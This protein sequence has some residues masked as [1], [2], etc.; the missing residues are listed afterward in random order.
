MA[1]GS[2]R[3]VLR[4]VASVVGALVVLLVALTL[5]LQTSAVSERVKDLVVPK[6]SAALGREVAVRAAKLRL[7]PHARVELE[8]T[9]VAGRPGEPPLVQLDAFEVGVRVWP[10]VTS[11][12][13]N[14]QVNEIRLVRPVVNLVR[15]KDGTW[16]YEGLGG[17]TEA[18]AEPA[19]QTKEGSGGTANV[20]VDHAAI[21]NGEV[22]YIDAL[23]GAHAAVA[24]SK[25]DLSAADVGLGHPLVAKISAAIVNPEKNFELD[26]HASKLPASLAALGPGQYPELEGRMALTGLDLSRVRAFMP[27]SVTH[28]MTGGRVDASA[29]LATEQGKYRVDGDGK[30]SQVRLR[31]EPAQGGFELHAI[32]DPATGAGTAS[33]EKIAL[34]GPGVDLGGNVTADLKPPRV[35]FAIAGPLLDLG[36]VMG[37]LPQEQKP[38]EQQPKKQ[39]G[40]LLTAEQRGHVRALD[41]AGTVDIHKV[42]KGGL[43]ANDFHAKAV[44]EHGVF[45]LQDA[46]TQFFGGRVDSG[47]TRVDLAQANPAWNLKAKLQAVDVGQAMQSLSG[48]APL[49]GKL[50]GTVDL[51]GAGVDWPAV[52]KVLTGHGVLSLKEGE[53][54]TADL[55]GQARGAVSQGLAGTGKSMGNKVSGGTG[56]TPLRDVSASFTVKDGAMTLTK[57]M[58]LAAPFGGAQLGG[59]IGLDG[60]LALQGTATL[61]KQAVQGASGG[62]AP[63]NGAQVPLKIGGTL[64]KPSVNVD[65]AGLATG[66]AKQQMQ[67][68]EKDVQEKAKV[69]ARKGAEDLLRG[70]GK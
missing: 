68:V 15:A 17:K 39:A 34:K 43:V 53:L 57:P 44:L 62:K 3:T 23:A 67:Q 7:L 47:G 12:G 54:Q 63:L 24:I 21:E 14:V 70:L 36:H 22:H 60:A 42:V 30:L 51:D 64:S 61:S 50:G 45:V 55:G 59:H 13:K 48:S 35:R 46:H 66:A 2:G 33:L 28:L 49:T 38:Q 37:L 9:S 52:Q 69:Q 32:A 26:L 27:G 56:K 10:L 31:G 16:N 1:N 6:V 29:K 8:G 25:I 5:V 20:V 58:V 4:V 18:K 11:L 65:A 41:V 19:A 40:P